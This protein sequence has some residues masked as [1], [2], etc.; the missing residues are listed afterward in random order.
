MASEDTKTNESSAL[1][2]LQDKLKAQDIA[3]F[4]VPTQDAHLSEYV[5]DHDKRRAYI[6]GFTGS[7]GVAVVAQEKAALWTDGRYWNQAGKELSSQWQ[8]MKMGSSDAVPSVE[9]WLLD[10]CP[11]GSKI[12]I[13]PYLTT[14]DT[15]RK[16]SAKLKD[17]VDIECVEENLVDQVWGKD[18][19]EISKAKLIVHPV[20]FAGREAT[21]KID[22]V[23]NVL[24]EKKEEECDAIVVTMLDEIC[25]LLNLRGSDID[26]NPVF[27]SYCVVTHDDVVLFVDPEKVTDAVKEHIGVDA[28]GDSVKLKPYTELLEYLKT[29]L[30]GKKVWLNPETCNYAIFAALSKAE[31]T[32]HE[33]QSPIQ[34]LKAIKNETELEGFRK[35]HIRDGAAKT[36]WLAWLERTIAA[37][38][39]EWTEYKVAKKLEEFRKEQSKEEFRGLSFGS[40][41]STGAN[42]A[43]I[44]Y[45]PP[46]VG[47]KVV[48]PSKIYLI[49]S[50]AQYCDGTTDVTRTIHLQSPTEKEI[51]CFTRVLRGHIAL[52]RAKFPERIPGHMLDTFARA[53]LWEAGL[54]YNHG[55]GHGVGSYLNVHEGPQTVRF[56]TEGAPPKTVVGMRA[57]MVISNE[58]GYYEDGAFGMRVES[59]VIAKKVATK[60]TFNKMTFLE[61]ETITMIPIQKKLI[62]TSQ[63]SKAEIDWLNEYHQTVLEKLT[64]LMKDD[65]EVKFLEESCSPL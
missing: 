62:D 23:R 43:V 9:E 11:K 1:T 58:P 22:D 34:L 46:E 18:Q 41:S 3:A 65:D 35:C 14:V 52:A 50:G 64:P 51:D 6:S 21:D 10:V 40:I 45:Q 2:L 12:G 15:Y 4:L 42:G 56:F 60:Y 26:Y 37:G 57:G 28:D 33:K 38:N 8:L 55:T 19:P 44:H 30:S 24:K 25:W 27:V 54:N 59:L 36:R 5:S 61:F 17:S 49:D 29:E 32:F 16:L 20:E 48:D 39:T 63:L 7:A 47:S 13:D 53:P 31:A